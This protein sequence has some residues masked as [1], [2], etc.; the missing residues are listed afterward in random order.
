VGILKKGKEII[1]IIQRVDHLDLH[2]K[3]CDLNADLQNLTK[4]NFELKQKN[5]E[6]TKQLNLKHESHFNESGHLMEEDEFPFC[7][8]FLGG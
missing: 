6:L 3:I 2:K 1:Q 8:R 4:E 7:P 5:E